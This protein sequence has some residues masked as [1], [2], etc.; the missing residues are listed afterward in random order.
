[1]LFLVHSACCKWLKCN[2]GILTIFSVENVLYL[3]LRALTCELERWNNVSQ[4]VYFCLRCFDVVTL[5]MHV[6]FFVLFCT[7]TFLFL[8]VFPTS[9]KSILCCYLTKYVHR[10]VLSICCL[11]L[12]KCHD[13]FCCCNK[14][15]FQYSGCYFGTKINSLVTKK[16]GLLCHI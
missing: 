1:M 7:S 5:Y 4:S 6:L 2:E 10:L 9:G 16:G 13:Y 15:Y 3:L 14:R 11:Y 12:Y 8:S